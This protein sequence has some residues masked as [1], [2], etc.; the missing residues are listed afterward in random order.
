MTNVYC[1]VY[2]CN[3]DSQL[4]TNRNVNFF[5]SPCGKTPEQKS[6]RAA[7]EEFFKRKAFKPSLCTRICSLHCAEESYEPPHS[8]QFLESIG[9]TEKTSLRLKPNALPTLDKPTA[10][11][12]VSNVSASSKS[13]RTRRQTEKRQRQK[14]PVLE[15]YISQ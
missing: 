3:S 5:R 15:R 2:G 7:W 1:P 12:S 14:V 6:R 9:Y 4:K 11:P 13:K 8:P 10:S